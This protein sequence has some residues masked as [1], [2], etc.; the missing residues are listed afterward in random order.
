MNKLILGALCAAGEGFMIYFLVQLW[1]D[2]RR[3]TPK[4]A[5]ALGTAG[6]RVLEF[7]PM[8]SG[9]QRPNQSVYGAGEVERG[10]SARGR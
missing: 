5:A 3:K 8:R 1:R 7:A 4:P 9:G 6:R 10:A 2:S